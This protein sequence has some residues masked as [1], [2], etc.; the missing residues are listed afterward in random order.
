MKKII[1]AFK[2]VTRNKN[3]DL[4]LRNGAPESPTFSAI[5]MVNPTA[6]Q[7]KALAL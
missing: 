5:A 4:T 6:L 1:D 3:V 7:W 2:Y